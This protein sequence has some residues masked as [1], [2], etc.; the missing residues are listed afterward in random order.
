MFE[1]LTNDVINFEQMGPGLVL[2]ILFHW[3]DCFMS[4]PV[5]DPKTVLSNIQYVQSSYVH[6]LPAST[7]D[8]EISL[9]FMIT[10]MC[11]I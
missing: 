2:A 11:Y 7:L 10:K 3:E 6:C 9:F 4:D 1:I 5:A 8:S